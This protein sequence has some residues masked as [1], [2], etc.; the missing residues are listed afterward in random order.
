MRERMASI[1]AFG[2]GVAIL[3]AVALWAFFQER[4][5]AGLEAP[6][7]PASWAELFPRQHQGL[8]R[9]ALSD[10]SYDKLAANPF[11]RRA[12]AGFGFELEYNAPRGHFYAQIDQRE[13]RR[14]RERDQPAACVHCH[15]AEAPALLEE[16][17]WEAF[18]ELRYDELRERLHHGTSCGDCHAAPSMKLTVSRPAFIEAMRRRGVDV[19]EASRDELRSYVCAQCHSEYYFRGPREELVFP[20][21]HGLRVEDIERHF[22]DYGFS[23][24]THGETGAPMIKIQHPDFE[25]Y[26]TSAHYARGV[27][28]ADCHMPHLRERGAVVSD[29]F[30]RSPLGQLGA[31]CGGC[32]AAPEDWLRDRVLAIQART[33]EQLGEAERALTELMDAIVEAGRAGADD[34]ALAEARRHHRRAQLRWDFIDAANSTGFHSPHEAAR[35]LVEAAELAREGMRRTPSSAEH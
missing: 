35:I 1:I 27:S 12:W 30:I 7:D 8:M 2:T 17:G 13:S 5:V 4:K 20:W 29:H 6:A 26:S 3:C 10:A 34:E 31:A 25:L 33:T 14:T 32:H 18:H 9:T 24:W 16:H 21:D 28:C 15:A 22:D 19:S 11:R 23:D